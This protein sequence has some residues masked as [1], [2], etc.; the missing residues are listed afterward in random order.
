VAVKPTEQLPHGE[1]SGSVRIKT[2]LNDHPLTVPFH[3]TFETSSIS[4]S[5]ERINLPPRL[6]LKQ[7][8]HIPPM[9]LTVRYG[10]CKTCEVRSV[11]PA[12]LQ[13]SVSQ[14]D[15]KTWRLQVHLPATIDE[16]RSKLS[17]KEWRQLQ[18]FG[19]ESGEII[20]RLDHP[21]VKQVSIPISG[22]LLEF[23]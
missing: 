11:S 10:T 5:Q 17:D 1:F 12:F 2:S 7:G 8:Y 9:I 21:D 6:A 19:Y 23:E 15:A 3:G 13:V 16:I 22:C 4:L 14:Q 20:L 18:A